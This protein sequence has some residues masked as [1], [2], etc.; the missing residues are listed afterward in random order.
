MSLAIKNN[1]PG[2]LRYVGQAGATND[3]SGFAKFDNPQNGYAALLNDVQGKLT[4]ATSTG[5]TPNHT[6]EDFAKVYAPPIEN[7][8]GDYVANLANTL[9]V[10]PN[11]KLSDIQNRAPDLAKAISKNEDTDFYNKYLGQSQPAQ[12]QGMPEEVKYNPQI[13]QPDASQ[14]INTQEEQN[15]VVSKT[16][17]GALGARLKDISSAITDTSW[18]PFG[19][20]QGKQ[21]L[22]SGVLQT[23]GG[24]AGGLGDVVNSAIENTPIV[25]GVVKSLENKL[26]SGITSYLSSESGKNILDGLATFTKEH[27]ELSKDIGAGVNILSAIPILKGIG[28]AQGLVLDAGSSAIKSIAEKSVSEGLKKIV[29]STKTGIKDLARNPEAINT[30]I[31]ERALPEIVDGKYSTKDA[32]NTLKT[33]IDD[34]EDELQ[35]VLSQGNTG[36]VASQVSLE[37]YKK[38]ALQNAVDELKDEVPIENY[39]NRLKKKYGDY[40]TIQQLNEAKRLVSR[41]I[42]EAGFNS[43]T[44]STDKIV[45]SILQQSVEDG[46]KMLGLDDVSIIN[47]K[48][49]NLIKSQDLLGHIEGK[50]VKLGLVGNAM[51]T[52]STAAGAGL[53]AISGFSPEVS[54]YFGNKI[55]K[56]IGKGIS[57][58]YLNV[59]RR[60]GKNAVRTT[61]KDVI[62]GVKNIGEGLLGMQPPNNK[63]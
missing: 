22:I 30:M 11:T 31:K 25:G 17:G 4:G 39:F 53:G 15:S 7:N 29:S 24:I 38:K 18:N 36:K 2:N 8:T 37:E 20:N 54:A 19:E 61:T 56:N 52:G 10:A 28:I 14:S 62:R 50:N 16:L 3:P 35:N 9:G 59:L 49:A 12:I 57:G 33:G 63:N 60:T 13:P 21:N 27:P 32:F 46:A 42:T 51:Q 58:G 43:A 41:N 1:N 55:G 23:A 48:M 47:Q 40:P 6:L 5:L 26:G 34:I 45:R 44:Q